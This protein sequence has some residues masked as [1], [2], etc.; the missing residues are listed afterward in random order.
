MRKLSV[1]GALAL[2]IVGAS[3]GPAVAAD[4][5]E[6]LTSDTC[7]KELKVDTTGEPMS[8]VIDAEDGDLITSYCVKAGSVKQG[9]GP[10]L[11][12]L[13]KPA[14]TVTITY[15]NA[16]KAISHYAVYTQDSPMPEPSTDPSADPSVSPSPLVSTSPSASP[17]GA[18]GDPTATPSTAVAGAT[19]TAAGD[20][21]VLANTGAAGVA[22]VS[23]IALALA[24]WGVTLLVLRRRR[25]S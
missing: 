15:P 5:I 13:E 14:S 2:L 12:T 1:L 19:D 18:A 7:P 10:V 21:P 22:G 8:I 3:A 23:L 9:L 25:M 20:P 4:T 11:V 16:E 17:S 6:V 24:G